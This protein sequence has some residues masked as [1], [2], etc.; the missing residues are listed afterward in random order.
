MTARTA[1]RLAAL[2]ATLA[3]SPAGPAAAGP[4]ELGD[5]RWGHDLPAA[6]AE[7]RRSGRPVLVLFQEIPG[8]ATCTGFGD[9]PLS[10]P[11]LVE[12][13]ESEFVPVA[14]RNNTSDPPDA[15]V[16]ERLGEHAY[17][18]PVF[19]ILDADGRDVIARRDGI[20][21]EDAVAARLAEALRAA[22]RPV[23][24]WLSDLAGELGGPRASV[25]IATACFWDGEA[26][27]GGVPGVRGTRAV[28]AHGHEAVE[29][30]YD[31]A[32]VAP[33]ALVRGAAGTRV[34]ADGATLAPE[35]DQLRHLHFSPLRW[36]P[37]TPLQATRVNAALA[38]H[39][40]PDSLLSPRQA[41][42]RDAIATALAR[43][44]H[45]LDGLERP[46]E[47]DGLADY[48]KRLAA[49]LACAR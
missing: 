48:Q 41:R 33:E 16:R 30:T 27:L 22:R 36:L 46:L 15:Q 44:P 12:A 17:D 43:D 28:Y 29:A 18:N 49:R 24:G 32:R 14:F 37:L 6:F 26:A 21:S 34:S 13:I 25:T 38:A 19:R 8:C 9:G 10:Q 31:P 1:A 42:L 47:R 11:L 40:S 39:A 20:W 4:R 3:A 35:S 7:A 23:P 5:V 2:V 45:A